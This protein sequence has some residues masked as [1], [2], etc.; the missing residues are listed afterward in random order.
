VTTGRDPISE[1]GGLNL[2]GMVSNEGIRNIDYLGFT[3]FSDCKKETITLPT[4]ETKLTVFGKKVE[5]RLSLART[6]ETC[7]CCDGKKGSF[8]KVT[9]YKGKTYIYAKTYLYGGE[10]P[11][12]SDVYSAWAGI[13]LSGE[14]SASITG[15]QEFT[16]CDIDNKITIKG[17]IGG[18]VSLTG[19]G[20]AKAS[21]GVLKLRAGLVITGTVS[22][23][24]W[25]ASAECDSSGCRN[26][27]VQPGSLKWNATA[28]AHFSTF[29]Y[30]RIFAGGDVFGF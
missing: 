17:A 6:N 4:L 26:F 9:E 22:F 15:K 24:S 19:G 25:I 7:G 16:N 2:Y 30:S 21:I 8:T 29:S 10:L 28:T 1:Q 20:E 11:G 3:S 12:G 27:N 14:L 18:A 23:D 13:R 5:G